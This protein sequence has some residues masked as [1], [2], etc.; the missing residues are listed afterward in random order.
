MHQFS[1]TIS[2]YARVASSSVRSE[3]EVMIVRFRHNNTN[4]CTCL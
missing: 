2:I 3:L 4:W 1:V